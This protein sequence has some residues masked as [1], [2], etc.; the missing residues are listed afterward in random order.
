MEYALTVWRMRGFTV[1]RPTRLREKPESNL[2]GGGNH[3]Y[4]KAAGV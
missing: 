3:E 2:Q 1:K 4:F